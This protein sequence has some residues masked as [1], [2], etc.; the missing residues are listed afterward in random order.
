MEGLAN[1]SILKLERWDK[2]MCMKENV[3]KLFASIAIGIIIALIISLLFYYGAFATITV[4]AQF[5]L[6]LA[7]ASIGVLAILS[8][9]DNGLTRANLNKN[10]I[11]NL[12]GIIG[13]IAF[14]LIALAVTLTI[15]TVL[16]SI[17]VGIF[18]FFLI[19]NLLSIL[20]TLLC[21]MRY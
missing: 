13:N 12:I 10:G 1:P 6:L 2:N 11:S 15:G 9:S 18:I 19:L 5:G 17:I 21:V 7:L 16:S 20:E 14:S 4:V 3:C 8:I